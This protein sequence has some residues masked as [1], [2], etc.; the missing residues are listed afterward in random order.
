MH[1]EE[2]SELSLGRSTLFCCLSCGVPFAFPDDSYITTKQ[3]AVKIIRFTHFVRK[4]MR[5]N[6]R[7]MASTLQWHLNK[8]HYAHSFLHPSIQK[9]CLEPPSK[10][11]DAA[12]SHLTAAW[13][14]QPLFLKA[15]NDL[16]R[17]LHFKNAPDRLKCFKITEDLLDFT[18]PWCNACNVAATN[19]TRLKQLLRV[20]QQ[21]RFLFSQWTLLANKAYKKMHSFF[22][23]IQKNAQ[24]LFVHTQTD[25]VLGRKPFPNVPNP[26]NLPTGTSAFLCCMASFHSHII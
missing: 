21:G 23:C 13:A 6:D 22:S 18:S 2:V 14:D 19:H 10:H 7:S 4:H 1:R 12:A 26:K 15:C 8:A 5:T 3:E 16:L 17:S 9:V 24:L 20:Q 25:S 11:K